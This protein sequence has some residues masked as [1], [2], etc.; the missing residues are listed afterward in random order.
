[1]RKL[2]RMAA[3]AFTTIALAGVGIA[4]DRKEGPVE[5]AGEAVDDA[6][7]DVQDKAEEMGKD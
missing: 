3:V 4:C 5:E 2:Q 7:D 1:M 6:V